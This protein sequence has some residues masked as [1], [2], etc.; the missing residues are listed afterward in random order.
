MNQVALARY[1]D[2]T[3]GLFHASFVRR[4]FL[5]GE[6]ALIDW[7]YCNGIKDIDLVNADGSHVAWILS[8]KVS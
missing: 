1:L 2:G 7:A 3:Q 6:K 5:A 4:L 8:G